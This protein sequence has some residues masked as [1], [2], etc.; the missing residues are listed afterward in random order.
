[1]R[2]TFRRDLAL[3]PGPEFRL[4]R[5]RSA[6]FLSA[7]LAVAAAGWGAYD[8]WA[9]SRVIGL[10]TTALAVAFF[11]QFIQGELAGWRFEGKELR[12]RRLRVAAKDIESVHV[13]FLGGRGRAWV[14]TRGGEELALVEG[15]ERDVRRIADRLSDTI[16]LAAFPPGRTIN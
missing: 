9:G 13:S 1:V 15:E 12:S 8:L 14:E 11:L 7:L 16:R 2:G 5:R 4:S 6:R 10:A 3:A